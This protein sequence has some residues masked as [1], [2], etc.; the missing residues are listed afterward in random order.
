MAK[1]VILTYARLKELEAELE[2][3]KSEKRKE[4][5][6]KI[7][8]ARGFGDLSENAEYDEAKKEQGEVEVKIVNLEK[9]LKSAKV[10]DEDEID[11]SKVV[12]GTKVKILDIDFNEEAEYEI[13]GSTEANPATGKISDESPLGKALLGAVPNDVVKVISPNGEYEVKVLSISK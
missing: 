3:L 1:E 12:V 8:V 2:Y 4:I 11:T 7:K 5:S 10:I 9:M 13:V 6:E